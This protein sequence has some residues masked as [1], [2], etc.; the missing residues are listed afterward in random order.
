MCF[1]HDSRPPIPPVEGGAIDAR[2]I[3]LDAADGNRFA[4]Y[5]AHA[6][7]PTGAG[8]VILPD[9]RGLHAYYR[10]LAIRFA[11]HGVDAVALDYFG[12]TA[13]IG[14]RGPGFDWAQHVPQTTYEGLR[15]DTAAATAH[16]RATTDA[17]RVFTIGFCMGGRLAFLSAGFN[18]GL[19]GVIGFYGWPV[20][21]SRNGTPAPAD[22]AASFDCPVLAIFGGADEGIGAEAVATFATAHGGRR[23]GE[24]RGDLSGCAPQ[25]LR[26]QGGGVRSHVVTGLGRGG[27]V[28]RRSGRSPTVSFLRRLLGGTPERAPDTADGDAGA[29][30]GAADEE[31]ARERDLLRGEALRLDDELIQRQLRY[32]SRAWTPPAQGGT[33]RADDAD[34]PSGEA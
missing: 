15:A 28:H 23:R 27:L 6:A 11:E 1:D 19:A 13:G 20:G 26:P 32:A 33:R 10:D 4:A 31:W 34:A 12:R 8:I 22:V 18:L 25:L 14:D 5:E 21:P 7:A 30:A 24:P 16:L 2:E 9:V 29:P 17:G 3:E